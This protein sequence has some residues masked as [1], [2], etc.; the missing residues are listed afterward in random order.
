MVNG[1]AHYLKCQY[2]L[3]LV[4]GSTNLLTFFVMINSLRI[5]FHLLKVVLD[6]LIY[7]ALWFFFSVDKQL[8]SEK[9]IGKFKAN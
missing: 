2:T 9:Q 4:C 1:A 6:Y 8:N 3:V 7:Y 5:L